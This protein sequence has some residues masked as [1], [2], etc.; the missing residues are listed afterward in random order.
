MKNPKIEP[1]WYHELQEVYGTD[2]PLG[3]EGVKVRHTKTGEITD[4]PAKGVFVA[5][6]HALVPVRAH[7]HALAAARG[8]MESE[9]DAEA[10]A[11][12]AMGI[13]ADICVYTNGNLTIEAIGT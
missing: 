3:V 7:H 4:I 11:R 1:L 12:K 6:G 9:L 5:I 2:S 10:I 8:L 13:A